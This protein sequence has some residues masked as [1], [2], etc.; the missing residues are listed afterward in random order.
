M[1]ALLSAGLFLLTYGFIASEKINKTIVTIVAVGIAIFLHLISFH[2]AVAAIDFNVIFLLIGM[3]ISVHILSKTGFFEW[4][5]VTLAKAAKGE[6]LRIMVFLLLVT[7]IFSAFLDNVTTII[8]IVPVTILIAQILEINPQPFVICEAIASNIGGTATLIGDPPNIIIGSHA[9]LS[10][11]QFLLHLGPVIAIVFS[12]FLFTIILI[13]RNSF[14]IDDRLKLRVTKAVPNLAIVD[15]PNMIRSLVIFGLMFAA[16]F[17]HTLIGVEPGLIAIVFSMVML[18]ICGHEGD[19]VI[20]S[21]EW[22]II[23]FFIGLFMLVATLE[24]NGV[25]AFAGKGLI[26]SIGDNLLGL[27]LVVLW[28]SAILS[29][30]LDNIPFVISMVPLIQSVIDHLALQHHDM[31]FVQAHIAQPLWWSLALGACLGG[32]GSL[33]GASANVVMAKIAGRN[34]CHVSFGRFFMYGMPFMIQSLIIS[35][36]YIWIRYFVMG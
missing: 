11:N 10:F 26:N 2:E 6:P 31:A 21:A 36:L 18:F 29:A 3:M 20:G 9:G 13:S 28:G 34:Q 17:L 8:L 23:F 7:T 24:V 27:C 4:I 35:S 1:K 25:I 33:I 30:I 14:K 12:V 32:N 16:F 15:K 19:E 5:A 22:G